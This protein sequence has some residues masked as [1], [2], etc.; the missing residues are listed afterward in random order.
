MAS[1]LEL[2]HLCELK[3]STKGRLVFNDAIRDCL[4]R[5]RAVVDSLRDLHEA[6]QR[7][8]TY[9]LAGIEQVTTALEALTNARDVMER[10]GRDMPIEKLR[11]NRERI[12]AVEK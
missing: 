8:K 4:V 5:G 7:M 11:I 3:K 1:T 10:V 2:I 6:H 9:E 12:T